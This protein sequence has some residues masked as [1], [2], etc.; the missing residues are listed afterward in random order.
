MTDRMNSGAPVLGQCGPLSAAGT[1]WSIV[2]T[3]D[4]VALERGL[5]DGGWLRLVAWDAAT[6]DPATDVLPTGA[7]EPAILTRYVNE[8]VG[9]D[10]VS[11]WADTGR[12]LLVRAEDVVRDAH[13]RPWDVGDAADAAG[14][15][16]YKEEMEAEHE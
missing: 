12:A 15:A 2:Q 9:G 14:D 6:D 1:D 5:P 4:G 10:V 13:P 7:D 8:G 3:E 11:E 16:A